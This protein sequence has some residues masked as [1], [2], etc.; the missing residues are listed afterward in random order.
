MTTSCSHL[1]CVSYNSWAKSDIW[2]RWLW[3]W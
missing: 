1:P 3:T 2:W